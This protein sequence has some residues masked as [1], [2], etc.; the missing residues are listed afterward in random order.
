[1]KRPHVFWGTGGSC[2]STIVLTISLKVK[3]LIRR[4]KTL[5]LGEECESL[6]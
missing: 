1:M 5:S 4:A 3:K 2:L 6:S